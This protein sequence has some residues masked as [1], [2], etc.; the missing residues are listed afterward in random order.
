MFVRTAARSTESGRGIA[1]AERGVRTDSSAEAI[2]AN[3]TDSRVKAS[4]E[5]RP[6]PETALARRSSQPATRNSQL[7]FTTFSR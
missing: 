4:C 2:P 6:R 5:E 7:P 3:R 1:T